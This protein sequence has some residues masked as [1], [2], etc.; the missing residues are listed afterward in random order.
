MI[1]TSNFRQTILLG[2]IILNLISTWL[3]YIDNA[4]FLS[5]YPGPTWFTSVGVISTVIV[6]TI[7][8]ILGYWFYT[9]GM[10]WLAYFL[11]GLYSI[12]SISSPVHYL[13]PMVA[14]MSLKMHS[15][16]WLDGVMGLLLIVFLLW[17]SFILKEWR[18]T[19]ARN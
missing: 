3:H 12:T 16:I 1:N 8:G 13:F 18:S 9:K 7:V 17:S 14:P 6:M 4:L 15:L 19:L 2:I 11:L 10:F 5:R